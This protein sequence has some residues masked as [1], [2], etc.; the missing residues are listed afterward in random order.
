MIFD[1]LIY[2]LRLCNIFV[3]NQ[4]NSPTMHSPLNQLFRQ[5]NF[6]DSEGMKKDGLYLLDDNTWFNK[7]SVKVEDVLKKIKPSAFFAN[8]SEHYFSENSFILFFELQNRDSDKIKEIH[9]A[10][11]N[12]GKTP[13]V[14][15]ILPDELQI[16]NGFS[17]N[18]S[19]GLLNELANQDD[20]SN[21]DYW[22]LIS[23]NTWNIYE[24]SL[25]NTKNKVDN[26]LLKNIFDARELLKGQGLSS[27]LA[28][29]LIGRL[30]FTRYLIDRNVDIIFNDTKFEIN[31]FENILESQRPENLYS[32]FRFLNSKFLSSAN[33]KLFPVRNPNVP[34]KYLDL[35]EEIVSSQCVKIL[36]DLFKGNIVKNGQLII[37]FNEFKY[38]DFEIIPVEFISNIYEFFMGESQFENK[39]FYTPLFLAEYIVNQTVIQYFRNNPNEYNCRVLDPSCGS[40]IFLVE[41]L[42]QIITRFQ[43]IKKI[44][45]KQLNEHLSNLVTD[46]IFGVDKDPAAINV[47]IFSIY[48][49]LL[50]F[51]DPKDIAN[52]KFP[53]LRDNFFEGDFFDDR[54]TQEYLFREKVI[55]TSFDYILGNPPW[56]NV[57][58]YQKK[59][60]DYSKKRAKKEGYKDIISGSEIA[61]AFVLRTSDLFNNKKPISCALIVTSKVLYN[62]KANNFRN[63]FLS[64]FEINQVVELSPVRDKVFKKDGPNIK[65]LKKTTSG[66]AA[67]IF[68]KFTGKSA[69]Q[70]NIIKHISI[71]SNKYFDLFRA[72]VI[73]KYDCKEVIQGYFIQYPWLWK[74]L[75]YG[76]LLDFY[77][78]KRLKSSRFETI[79]I[80]IDKNNLKHGQG[81]QINKKNRK[82]DAYFVGWRYLN[83]K[84]KMLRRF[85]IDTNIIEYWTESLLYRGKKEERYL[86]EPPYVLLKSGLTNNLKP[87]AAYSEDQFVFTD[88]VN[89]IKGD[90]TQRSLLKNLAGIFNSNLYTYY[91]LNV[92]A[93]AAIE[94][95]QIQKEEIF[96]FPF[97]ENEKIANYVDRIQ[98]YYKNQP[99]NE[100]EICPLEKDLDSLLYQLYRLNST[101]K[102]LLDYAFNISI[103][104]WKGEKKPY[105]SLN[106]PQD[107]TIIDKY[108]NVFIKH[109]STIYNVENDNYFKA[110]IFYSKQVIAINFVISQSEP[111]EY[112][113]WKKE[114][115]NQ[116]IIL[117][118]FIG[119]GFEKQASNLY[120][121]KDIKG[122]ND[123][124]FYIIKPNEY[125]VWHEAVAY[126]DLNEIIESIFQNTE[127]LELVEA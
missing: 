92:G 95:E 20:K 8:P 83:T 109:F 96:D 58:E 119:L 3:N 52:F 76:N 102:S 29:S 90:D 118:N 14:F 86:F 5:L 33:E 7:F 80:A 50:D 25:K 49:T 32:W 117:K 30:I 99:F 59:Y 43:A 10:C 27:E 31:A 38:Y 21:F 125:K 77:L 53:P 69:N 101:E 12:F 82:E 126:L 115:K 98:D 79:Q 78:T 103:P 16:I 46:N 97:I 61:Q 73:E 66:P 106:V 87:V 47:A 56:G 48:I 64:K 28:N 11:W 34:S 67:I 107:K 112:I 36:Y 6:I 71:K 113:E 108:V 81:V 17:F 39:A 24:N 55:E 85:S 37:N 19:E 57:S 4:L 91:F 42:R 100:H 93:S 120:V 122:F 114:I 44:E 94:R 89:S 13:V 65:E 22:E 70:E 75:V 45:R 35:S 116:E 105:Q 15:I 88:S 123:S 23:G 9:K 1:D 40:G 60:L 111:D 41:T 74:V 63:F 124:S 2:L 72:F 18:S 110:E 68:Y 84:Q 54:F 121:Q 104:L 127:E 62:I 26:T 51:Q